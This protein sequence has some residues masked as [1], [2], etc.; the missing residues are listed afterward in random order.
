MHLSPD[1]EEI[2]R[3]FHDLVAKR[4]AESLSTEEQH[5]LLELTDR[6]EEFDA[7]RVELLAKLARECN[8]TLTELMAE[9][10]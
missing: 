4:K 9:T 8:V 1:I 7:R 3:R 2:R 6:I 5:E 10:S